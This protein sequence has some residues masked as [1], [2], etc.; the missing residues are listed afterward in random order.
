[1][2]GPAVGPMVGP[3]IGPV[4][5][6]AT[7]P[8]ALAA[9]LAVPLLGA[10]GLAI[11]RSGRRQECA[12]LRDQLVDAAR[13]G[14]LDVAD[15]RVVSLIDWLDQVATT[16]RTGIPGRHARHRREPADSLAHSLATTLV[17]LG[18]PGLVGASW[19]LPPQPGLGSDLRS[20]AEAYR[21]RHQPI[22][23]RPRRPAPPRVRG[24]VTGQAQP[25]LL[26]R[27]ATRPATEPLARPATGP[28]ARPATRL[29]ARPATGP[30]A[31]PRTGSLVRP[32]TGSRAGTLRGA[33]IGSLTGPLTSWASVDPDPVEVRRR[34]ERMDARPTLGRVEPARPAPAA[35]VLPSL[36][37]EIFAVAGPAR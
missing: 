33:V 8:G 21:E 22:R 32:A 16:G 29:L 27:P 12:R 14:E 28:L 15:R 26:T 11:R 23:Y 2:I 36:V 25:E 24:A 5:D 9:V 19:P 34:P 30:R 4:I 31:S 18:P 6:S 10:L 7:G 37:E 35:L 1:M 20:A 3:T 17:T 13:S